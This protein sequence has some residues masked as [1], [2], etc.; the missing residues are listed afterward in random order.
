[1]EGQDTAAPDAISVMLVDDSA[2]IRGLMSRALKQKPELHIAATASDGEMAIEVIQHHNVDV[3]VLDIEMPKMDGLTALPKLLEL[4]PKSAV[5]IVS[6]LSQRN[7]EISIRALS[8]GA[9]DYIPKPTTSEGAQAAEQFY[10]ELRQKVVALGLAARENKLIHGFAPPPAAPEGASATAEAHPALSPQIYPE[11]GVRAVAIT[12]STGGPQALSALLLGL[13]GTQLNAPIFITQHMP[14][15]FTTMLAEHI[16][17]DTG[18]KC[19]EANDQELVA[20][21]T[22]YIAPGDYHML[23]ERNSLGLMISLSHDPPIN[24]CRPAADPMFAS[25]AAAYKQHLLAVVLTGMGHDGL[26]GA[27]AV[28]K[29]GGTVLAQDESTSVVWGMPGAVANARLARAVLPLPEIAAY[30]HHVMA[31]GQS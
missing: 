3:I 17:R 27:E 16:A 1:M 10:D 23:V 9:A 28:V 11:A 19:R 31:G 4:S 18:L 20:T 22:I 8:L 15:K 6:T 2:V 29:H 7:A 24:F 12:A 5:L 26:H 25:L 30:L 14:A 13:K 21:G